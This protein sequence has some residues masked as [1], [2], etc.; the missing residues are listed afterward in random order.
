MYVNVYAK[1]Y[2]ER[3]HPKL[4]SKTN[5]LI[6]NIASFYTSYNPPRLPHD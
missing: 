3:F 6:K 4:I 2:Y 5:C 1:P